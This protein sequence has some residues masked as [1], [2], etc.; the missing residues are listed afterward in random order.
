[1]SNPTSLTPFPNAIFWNWCTIIILGIGNS[2]Y[3]VDLT[4]G[5]N[6]VVAVGALDFQVRCMAAKTP[7][8]ATL[9][10]IIGGCLTF[11]FGVPF[12]YLGAITR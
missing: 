8:V 6:T 3:L 10:C 4:N 9:G 2:T 7:R 5:S 1:M 12:S 11:L